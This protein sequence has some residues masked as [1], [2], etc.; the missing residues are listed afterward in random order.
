MTVTALN[1]LVDMK[2]E[3]IKV[4]TQTAKTVFDVSALEAEATETSSRI[5]G[6][7]SE[8]ENHVMTNASQIQNQV[9]YEEKYNDLASRYQM[10]LDKLAELDQRILDK[11]GRK[12]VVTEF[13]KKLENLELVS[14]YSDDL[15]LTFVDYVTIDHE[16]HATYT[17]LDGTET[18]VDIPKRKY[19]FEK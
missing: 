14:E 5:E 9:E 12:V 2:M 7:A 4:M 1:Q 18:T 3:V 11:K 16:N 6:L 15:F 19:G 8:L 10:E 17:F 13:L